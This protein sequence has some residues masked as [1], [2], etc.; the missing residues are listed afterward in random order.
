MPSIGINKRSAS[1]RLKSSIKRAPRT[2][3]HYPM[4]VSPYRST[5]SGTQSKNM[6]EP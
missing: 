3:P 6:V 1:E 4:S 2:A 5:S